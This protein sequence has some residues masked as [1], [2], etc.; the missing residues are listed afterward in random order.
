MGAS[1]GIIE[2]FHLAMEVAVFLTG[3][4]AVSDSFVHLIAGIDDRL[5]V[6]LLQ[7]LLGERGYLL[8]GNQL[9][10]GKDGLCELA[11]R[12]PQQLAWVDDVTAGRVGPSGT[13]TERDAGIEG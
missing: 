6:F 2:H 7:I 9:A 13:T 10:T 3:C 5:H 4:L 8:V 1:V 11:D 12:I